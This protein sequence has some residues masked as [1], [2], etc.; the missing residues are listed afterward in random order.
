MN[1]LDGFI[2]G[3]PADAAIASLVVPSRLSRP[4]TACAGLATA[5]CII[6]AAIQ[7]SYHRGGTTR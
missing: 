2:V 5:A 4:L 7:T 1:V 3:L 6:V